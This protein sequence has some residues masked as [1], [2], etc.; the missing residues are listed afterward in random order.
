MNSRTTL[1]PSAKPPSEL[2]RFLRFLRQRIDPEAA[3]LGPRARL[4][5]RRGRRVTQ[6][7]LAEAI[8]VSREWYAVLE[9]AATTRSSTGLLDRLADALMVTPEERA[10]LFELAV[11][12][13]GRAQ[14]HGDAIGAL[15]GFSR[16]QKLAR[17][18]WTATSVED[19]LSTASEQ[20]TDWFE[21]CVLVHASRRRESGLWESRTVDDKRD[22]SSASTIIRE[23][24]HDVLPTSQDVDALHLYPQLAHAGDTGAPELHPL[25]VRREVVKIFARR[26]I[27]G[28]TFVKARVR[29]RTGLVAGFC[30]VHELGHAYS[31]SDRAVLGAFAQIASLA[32]S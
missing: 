10:T 8:G 19:V 6:Q 21:G 16:L 13:F 18:L 20:I 2:A 31:A 22:R 1:R 4:P 14:L 30:V 26:R 32:L 7:E 28:F 3:Y 9:S 27:P 11:P 17:R 25:P 24:E 15:E 5:V 23:L 12:E 29:S